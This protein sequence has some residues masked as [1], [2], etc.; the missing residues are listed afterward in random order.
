MEV[1]RALLLERLA[2][3]A[4]AALLARRGL[5]SSAEF[6]ELVQLERKH[7]DEKWGKQDRSLAMWVTILAEEFGEFAQA[8]C[9]L[10]DGRATDVEHAIHEL[11]S[12]GAVAQ[13][14]FEQYF[15]REP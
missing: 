5:P 7:Q 2:G 14:I 15:R 6:V 1:N 3:Q 12:V 10:E 9:D 11:A 8:A 4:K 13:S